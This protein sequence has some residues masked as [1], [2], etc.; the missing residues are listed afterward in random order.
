MGVFDLELPVD[1]TLVQVGSPEPYLD[2]GLQLFDHADAATGQALAGQAAE[3]AFGTVVFQQPLPVAVLG[4]VRVL[5]HQRT[6][7][8]VDL[9]DRPHPPVRCHEVSGDSGNSRTAIPATHQ[10]TAAS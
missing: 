2:F 10:A 7:R 1:T 4:A 5:P 9:D 3:F 8:R 6:S